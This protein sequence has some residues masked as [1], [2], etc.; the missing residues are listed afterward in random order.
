MAEAYGQLFGE[1][2]RVK[3]TSGDGYPGIRSFGPSAGI[4]A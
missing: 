4:A 2:F 1:R 3:K